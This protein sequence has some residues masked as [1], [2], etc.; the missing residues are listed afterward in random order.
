[1]ARVCAHDDPCAPWRSPPPIE[2]VKE[3]AVEDIKL[4]GR[5]GVSAA[6]TGLR[7]AGQGLYAG[8][9]AMAAVPGRVYERVRPVVAPYAG[10]AA[11]I[12]SDRSTW[13]FDRLAPAF[14]FLRRP[15]IRRFLIGTG[16]IAAIGAAHRYYLVG[17]DQEVTYAGIIALSA[18]VLV[19]LPA[20]AEGARLHLIQR[21]SEAL[22]QLGFSLQRITFLDRFNA[23]QVG[24]VALAGVLALAG[25]GVWYA[26]GPALDAILPQLAKSEFGASHS[27]EG[28][29]TA[30]SGDSLRINGQ[31][32]N[33][34]GIEAPEREQICQRPK[35]G[36]W[37]CGDAARSVLD[38]L[39]RGRR[40]VC[41]LAGSS[42]DAKPLADCRIDGEDLAATLVREGHV[43][44]SPGAF[45]RYAGLEREAR[46]AS[47][48]LWFARRA[49]C[50]VSGQEMEK[51]SAPRRKGA[52]SR[53][54]C[55]EKP[56]S[57]FCRGRRP[58]TT[59]R[60]APPRANAGSA[61]RKRRVPPVGEPRRDYE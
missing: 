38:R 41:T 26:R 9:C 19:A 31:S 28:R 55:R 61:V 58:T 1:M 6:G 56:V 24:G 20:F 40:V 60:C 25:A 51:P 11:S 14:A 46:S 15:R 23:R 13:L 59:S 8:L 27:L 49:A 21:L 30:V 16:G 29:A 10:R 18:L 42:E 17:F 52:R 4:A 43:F 54:R 3:A 45:A 2:E 32:L 39:V 44:A 37:R 53:V 35:T 7:A 34:A 22:E 12:I 57:M 33:L 50:R 36:M 47:I 5:K 48:G